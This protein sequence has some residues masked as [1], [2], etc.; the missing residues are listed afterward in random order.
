MSPESRLPHPTGSIRG[1]FGGGDE[2]EGPVHIYA[3]D[4]ETSLS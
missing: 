2:G 4:Q 3:S 1:V